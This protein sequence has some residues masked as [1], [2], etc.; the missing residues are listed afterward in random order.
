MLGPEI[1]WEIAYAAIIKPAQ[2]A[3]KPLS[4]TLLGKMIATALYATQHAKLT[5]KM[6]PIIMKNRS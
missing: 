2:K 1:I 3:L 6:I 4:R 5:V